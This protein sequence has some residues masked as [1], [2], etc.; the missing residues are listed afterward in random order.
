M[1]ADRILE[2]I[3]PLTL[4]A[5]IAWAAST[6]AGGAEPLRLATSARFDITADGAVVK[7]DDGRVT[8]G[9]GS[10]ERMNWVSEEARPRGYT[11][12]FPITAL[13]WRNLAIQFVPAK[14]GT[15]TLALMGPY[16]EESKGVIYRQEV[17]WDGV[18]AEGTKLPDGGFETQGGQLPTGWQSG[19]GAVVEQT[20]EAPALDGTHFAR[21]WHNQTLS[22]TFEVAAGRPVTIRLSARA[23]RVAGLDEMKPIVSRQT[24]AHKA[25]RLFLRGANLGNDFEVPPGQNWAVN[26]TTDDTH[27]IRAEGFDHIRI[28]VGWHHYTGPAPDFT[29][30][31]AFFNRVDA[32]VN[33]GLREGLAVIINVH[34]FDEFTTDPSSQTPK[35]LAL[36]R[37]IARHYEKAAAKLAFE[38][39]NEPKDAA[40]TEV[41]NRVLPLAIAEIRKISP[42]RTIFV[43]PGRWNG[44]GE[45]PA[46]RLPDDDHNLIVTVHSYEPFLVTH[47]GATWTGPDTKLS[48]ILFPGPPAKPLV[49]DPSLGL[50]PW[51]LDWVKKYNTLPTATN[52]SG[53]SAFQGP[54]DQA[55]EWSQYY[56]RP[57]HIGE[58]GCFTGADPASRAHYYRAFRE[59]AEQAGLGW[60]IWDWRAGFRYWDEKTGR[61]EPGLHDALFATPQSS[62]L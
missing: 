16:Q 14:A 3:R 56:G 38:I 45:L 48:G 47:Q 59:A 42:E 17:L 21:T 19:G 43:G 44:I 39:L 36:W 61:P 35:L 5:A 28:P 41:M 33:A 25:A 6:A 27:N 58:F 22:T 23:A 55:R 7:I 50:A 60:A 57:V 11:I 2:S 46:F 29:I 9:T 34:H 26:Y 32:L 40:T 51:I 15:V 52:P 53:R 20:S 37:Q 31:P 10:I 8:D 13:G 30:R 62:R 4:L 54:I 18:S 24:P 1:I 49:P 12:N